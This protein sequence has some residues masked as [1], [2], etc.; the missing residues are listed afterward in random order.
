MFTR[1]NWLPIVVFIVAIAAVSVYLLRSPNTPKAPIKIYKAVE[2]DRPET[3]KP[4]PPGETAE[5]GHWHGDEWH[6]EPHETRAQ[7][8]NL[9]TRDK[10]E[11]EMGLMSAEEKASQEKARRKFYESHGLEPPPPGYKYAKIGEGTPKLVKYKEPILTVA[12]G[13]G[14]GRFD[15]LSAKDFERYSNLVSIDSEYMINRYQ[16]SPEVVALGK[17]QR[18][19]LYLKTKGPVPTVHANVVSKN[20]LTPQEMEKLDQRMAD[21]LD[22]LNPSVQSFKADFDIFEQLLVELRAEVERR[23]NE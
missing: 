3:Q 7:P 9:S 6:A 12:W 15:L 10:I 16:I 8:R 19:E 14:Y 5:S 23:K 13:E 18:D 21:L 22:E 4:P 11:A 17:E 2:V 20:G 1:K